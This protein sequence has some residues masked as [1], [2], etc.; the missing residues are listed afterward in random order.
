MAIEANGL[1]EAM[2]NPVSEVFANLSFTK[3]SIGGTE[4]VAVECGV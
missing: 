1:K 4:L 2:E 3:G